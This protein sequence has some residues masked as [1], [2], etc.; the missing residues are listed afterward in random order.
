ME[1][2][3]GAGSTFTTVALQGTKTS[4]TFLG[5]TGGYFEYQFWFPDAHRGQ[6]HYFLS[7][8]QMTPDHATCGLPVSVF[9]ML[10]QAAF[11]S[12]SPGLSLAFSLFS[13]S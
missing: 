5:N 2:S 1:M 8:Q 12:C 6:R 13:Q 3:D 10:G 7:L 4:N 9:H 11:S